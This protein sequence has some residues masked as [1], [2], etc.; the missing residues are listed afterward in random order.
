MT[1]LAAIRYLDSLVNYEKSTNYPYQE[2]LQLARIKDFLSLE[3]L[4][5][6]PILYHVLEIFE[7]E[8]RKKSLSQEKQDARKIENYENLL[9]KK[10]KSENKKDIIFSVIVID[11]ENNEQ[12]SAMCLRSLHEQ[13]FPAEN[14][15]IIVNEKKLDLGLFI[16]NSIEQAK[17]EIICFISGNCVAP[18]DWLVNFYATY[19]KYPDVAGV[20]G[21][22]RKFSQNYTIFDEYYYLELGKK[23]G[24]QKENRYL[25]KLYEI[26]NEFFYQN[27]AGIFTN[28][29]YKK[30]ILENLDID[31]QNPLLKMAEMEIK[32]QILRNNELC[33]LPLPVIDLNKTTLK[34]FIQSNFLEGLAFY[35]FCSANTQFKRYYNYNIFSVIKTPFLNIL[36]GYWKIK[37]SLIIL[38]GIFFRFF[39]Q[40][41]GKLLSYFSKTNNRSPVS[42]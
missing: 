31:Y 33:F 12:L 32:K 11:E 41:Y 5:E 16:K 19:Q 36:D 30:S 28:M 2:T 23:L 14:H 18:S 29:S 8:V 7:N 20:G 39:G 10:I 26:K 21:Y 34:K 25:N 6:R 27:P 4:P 17:G 40:W 1:Y 37:L 38:I 35:V 22:A 24:I 15:E 13:K 9:F 42:G 3:E